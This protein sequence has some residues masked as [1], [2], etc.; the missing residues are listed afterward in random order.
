MNSHK[1]RKS[2]KAQFFVKRKE[3]R[4]LNKNIV[5]CIINTTKSAK[6]KRQSVQS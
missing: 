3:A 2:L 4:I 6:T 5:I 1:P